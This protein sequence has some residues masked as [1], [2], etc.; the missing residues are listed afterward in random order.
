MLANTNQCTGCGLCSVVCPGKAIRMQTNEIG[1]LYPIVNEERCS[2]CDRCS[3]ACPILNRITLSERR[4]FL[5]VKNINDEVRKKSSSGGVFFELANNIIGC[6]GVV[7]AA[8][9][10]EDYSVSHK[11]AE[12]LEEVLPLC[13]AKYSQSRFD[14]CFENIKKRLQTGQKVLFVGTPCQTEALFLNCTKIE[15]DNL[16]LVDMICHGVP[17][18]MVFQGYLSEQS[19]AVAQGS[20]VLSIS[21][22]DKTTGWSNYSYSVKI[23]FENGTE[24]LKKQSDD[25]YMQGFVNNLYL[26]DSCEDCQFKGE[27]R[28]SDLT[29][30]DFWGIW[31]ITPEFD[32][33]QGVSVLTINSKKGAEL[34]NAICDDFAAISVTEKQAFEYN[35][36][37]LSSS[38]AHPNKQKFYELI[39]EN[40]DLKSAVQICLFGEKEKVSF[41]RKI[42]RVLN[43]D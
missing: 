18:P 11:F 29:L 3:Q 28:S 32:D 13:G 31:D 21:L 15:R 40:T 7:C 1:F 10:D 8:G 14:H 16:F 37:A 24:Y 42:K 6:G 19:K 34:W 4:Q 27:T 35:P 39:K 33:N 17:S 23:S 22:R 25:W 38:K 26:R 9:Y 36:S 2:S 5:A 12:S 20:S 41:W 30:G 43:N